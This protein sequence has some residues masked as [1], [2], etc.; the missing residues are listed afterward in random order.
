MTCIDRCIDPFLLQVF[1][2]ELDSAMADGNA[3]FLQSCE[4]NRIAVHTVP[5]FGV[6]GFGAALSHRVARQRKL[7]ERAVDN[8]VVL[9]ID[10]PADLVFSAEQT[11][12]L[13][14]FQDI[15]HPNKVGRPS[16]LSGFSSTRI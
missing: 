5:R 8:V 4:V 16:T 12:I 7:K 11:E 1:I 3:R 6:P 13:R 14:G 9:Y 15:T 10:N 2:P